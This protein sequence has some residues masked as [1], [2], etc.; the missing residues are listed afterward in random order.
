MDYPSA[1]LVVW[2]RTSLLS[3]FACCLVS[4]H[5]CI[6]LNAYYLTANDDT[7]FD[8]SSAIPVYRITFVGLQGQADGA[9]D[10]FQGV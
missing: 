8:T 2:G 6:K 10:T 5:Y 4:S 3:K 9:D 7:P 1:V